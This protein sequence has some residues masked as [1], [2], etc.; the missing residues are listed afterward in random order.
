MLAGNG[1]KDDPTDGEGC[2]PLLRAAEGGHEV[3][4]KLLLTQS[5]A[6]ANSKDVWADTTVTRSKGGDKAVVK[7]LLATGRVDLDFKEGDG[8]RYLAQ[9]REGMRR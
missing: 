5:D 2:T 1:L 7:L 3:L 9:Q 8:R 6:E 4:V